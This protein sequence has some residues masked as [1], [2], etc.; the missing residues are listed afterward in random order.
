MALISG[1]SRGIGATAARLFAAAGYDLL[2]LAR[3]S[4][5]FDALAAELGQSG[6]RVETIGLDLADS[7]A[8]GPVSKTSAAAVSS[9][10]W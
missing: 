1:A 10:P 3:P 6:R 9:H 7:T 2:L 8:V 5:E 4:Q